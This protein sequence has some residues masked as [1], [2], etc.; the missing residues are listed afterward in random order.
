VRVADARGAAA[1]IAF[2]GTGAI[3]T[4]HY[5]PTGGKA[6][7]YLDG[8]LHQ[9]VDAYPDE[10]GT[11]RSDSV[12]HAFGLTNGKHTL[13][14]VVRGEPHPDSQGADIVLEDLVVF[15]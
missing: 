2:E 11:K 8:K 13:R 10:G 1:E 5:L 4:G 6:D 9:T 14:L 7:V 12:W 3:L 15:R